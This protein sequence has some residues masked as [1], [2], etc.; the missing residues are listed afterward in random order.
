MTLDE[1]E[2]SLQFENPQ[3]I[4]NQERVDIMSVYLD[5]AD[6]E[7]S[8]Y[9]MNETFIG[10]T[11]LKTIFPADSQDKV[12]AVES[13]AQAGNSAVIA[14]ALTSVLVGGA[15]SHL[16]SLLNGMQLF[17]HFPLVSEFPAYSSLM[18]S[19]IIE[20]ATFDIISTV[21]LNNYEESDIFDAV[22]ETPEEQPTG[23]DANYKKFNDTGYESRF[24]IINLGMVFFT[25]VI[26]IG[27]AIATIVC[28]PCETRFIRV[29][30][31]VKKI[32]SGLF[33]N[34]FLRFMIEG[35]LEIF[36]GL[37]INLSINIKNNSEDGSFLGPWSGAFNITNNLFLI[38][39][40]ATCGFTL[41]FILLFYTIN[42]SKW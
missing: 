27:L 35:S 36:V 31:R 39:F 34:G 22:F 4:G 18:L 2:I 25:L 17:V 16:W 28:Y 32:R 9:G 7:P 24:I 23:V 33:W 42:F 15:I 30:R 5:F 29:E 40:P 8:Y 37:A 10:L 19:S 41:I 38:I 6:F 20:I 14:S 26:M 1:I 21:T 11:M 12:E 3:M 13:T